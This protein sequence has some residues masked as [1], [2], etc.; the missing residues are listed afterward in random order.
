LEREFPGVQLVHADA[1]SQEFHFLKPALERKLYALY[2]DYLRAWVG[3]HINTPYLWIDCDVLIRERLDFS[4]LPA[5]ATLAMAADF[6]THT[7][8]YADFHMR[9]W[10]A[11]QEM[12]KACGGGDPKLLR[13]EQGR[14]R[15]LNCGVILVR[16]N[17]GDLWKSTF[18]KCLPI[19]P[20]YKRM[21]DPPAKYL[22][23]A[24]STFGQGIWNVMYALRKGVELPWKWNN[25]KMIHPDRIGMVDHYAVDKDAFNRD[26]ASLGYGEG[27]A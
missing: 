18:E 27:Y 5:N 15:N 8:P 6:P 10:Q 14:A 20:E 1:Q 13:D 24:E 21:I 3:R 26:S 9:I 25:L 23:G 19:L 16:E 22:G 4:A 2:F 11:Y 7:I 12:L 17:V